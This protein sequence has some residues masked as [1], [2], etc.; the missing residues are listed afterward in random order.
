MYKIAVVGSPE[1]VVG[2]TALGL[3]A[4]AV[5]GHEDAVHIFRSLI[6]E[7]QPD[8]YA[9]IYVEEDLAQVLSE[10]IAKCKDRPLPAVILIPGSAGSLGI[11]QNSLREA[12]ERAVGGADIV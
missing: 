1:T 11:G 7:G 9:I 6:K 12:V 4:V 3:D 8:P 5:R 10:E 2:F